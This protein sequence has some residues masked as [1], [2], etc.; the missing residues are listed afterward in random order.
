[1]RFIDEVSLQLKAG[2]GG[3]GRISFRR[4]KYVPKGGPDGGDGGRGGDIVFRT[5]E[6]MASLLDFAYRHTFKAPAG[7]RGGTSN[8]TGKSGKDLILKMPIGTIIYNSDTNELIVDLDHK[9]A[10]FVVAKGGKGGQGNARFTRPSLRTPDW[11]QEGLPGEEVNIRLELKLVADVG[12]IGLPNAGKSTLVNAISAAK[13][14]VGDY[15]FTTLVPNLGV[16]RVDEERTFVV[17]DVPGLIAG[18][19]EGL[20]LGIRF[21]KH[22][23][24]TRCLVHLVDVSG[25]TDPVEAVRMIEDELRKYDPELL[26]RPRI[27]AASKV[28]SIYARDYALQLKAYAKSNGLAF[29]VL[30]SVTRKGLAP[31]VSALSKIL[32]AMDRAQAE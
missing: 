2:H 19:S 27:V 5:D 17:A 8:K 13:A 1:M 26:N 25:E 24:R 21:L 9:G 7:Q 23:Q 32:F 3:Q 29:T 12:V 18:A 28:D 22:I 6:R 30:S 11:A 4:E 31:L 20:G 14:K 10:E 15:P 16:V